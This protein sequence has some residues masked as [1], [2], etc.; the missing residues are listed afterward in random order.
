MYSVSTAGGDERRVSGLPPLPPQFLD[1]WALSPTGIY[2]I[3]PGPPRAGIDFFEFAQRQDCAP[4]RPPG[5]SGSLGRT[6]GD[7]TR[8]PAT[9]LPAARRRLE[10]HHARGKLPLTAL[11]RRNAGRGTRR[12]LAAQL[13]P[14]RRHEVPSRACSDVP[15]MGAR[16]GSSNTSGSSSSPRR[17]RLV[18]NAERVWARDV[19]LGAAILHAEAIVLRPLPL[20][21]RDRLLTFT[22]VRPGTNRQPPMAR[23]ARTVPPSRTRR[24]DR[25]QQLAQGRGPDVSG[26]L[27]QIDEHLIA[28]D[29]DVEGNHSR[30][31]H[32]HPRVVEVFD[33]KGRACWRLGVRSET[34]GPEA[35][36]TVAQGR[37]VHQSPVSRPARLVIPV[38][39]TRH[40]NPLVC[41][42]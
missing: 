9:S 40:A 29:R 13:R 15:T 19:D 27:S 1:A 17:V 35:M 10:R 12:T 34:L 7:L 4:R 33:G 8:R 41:L 20:S 28:R 26:Q 42:G 21:E 38:F 2:F 31:R 23:S 37:E 14:R 22:I 16:S 32:R 25:F 39:A 11:F 5:A 30:I 24:V 36:E 3:N 18:A 6:A